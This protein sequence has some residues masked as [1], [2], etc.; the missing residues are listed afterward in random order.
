MGLPANEA[1]DPVVRP[2]LGVAPARTSRPGNIE[3][4]H[5]TATPKTPYGLITRKRLRIGSGQ[6][7]LWTSTRAPS[8]AGLG[9]KW[10]ATVTRT[11][12]A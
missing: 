4:R 3:A 1:A 5:T 7:G 6:C 9:H 10:M 12:R 11:E 8:T 2:S